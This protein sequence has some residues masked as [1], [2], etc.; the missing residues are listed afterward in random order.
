MLLVI[1]RHGIAQDRDDPDCPPDPERRLTSKGIK[2]TREAARGLAGLKVEPRAVLSSPYRRAMETA[3][4][5]L[6]ALRPDG[7]SVV[8]TDALL[9][10]A[11]PGD[12]MRVLERIGEIPCALLT[13]HAPHLDLL[14]AHALGVG[15][16]VTELKK[17][18][19]ACIDLPRGQP[20]GT[21]L[22]LLEPGHLREMA[23]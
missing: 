19:A 11:P 17:A 14:I 3:E 23:E 20:P 16:P 22:W 9:P 12:V 10:G 21:L 8:P 2:R 6:A 4:L 5:A 18:G 1:L 13:G 7:V 15:R